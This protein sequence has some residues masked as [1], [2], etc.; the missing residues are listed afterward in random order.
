[1]DKRKT[2][3]FFCAIAAFLFACQYVTAGLYSSGSTSWSF[4]SFQF[5]LQCVGAWLPILGILS[6][7]TGI[8][9]LLSA[10]NAFKKI[11]EQNKEQ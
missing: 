3:V 1:M 2:G 8:I 7:A 11:R 4:D 9:Y 5:A 10:E 6:L